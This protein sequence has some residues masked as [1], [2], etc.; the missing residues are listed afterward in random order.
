M[1]ASLIAREL[2][3]TVREEYFWSPRNADNGSGAFTQRCGLEV[4][5][6]S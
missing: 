6:T 2:G 4:R 1:V 5:S 3:G